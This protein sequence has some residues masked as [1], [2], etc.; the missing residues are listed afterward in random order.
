MVALFFD[1]MLADLLHQLRD[2]APAVALLVQHLVLTMVAM[3]LVADRDLGLFEVFQVGPI[4]AGRIV[5]GK[6]LAHLLVG[7]AVSAALLVGVAR[8]LEPNSVALKELIRKAKV[9]GATA[10]AS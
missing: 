10:A 9:E 5:V 2:A 3:S 4:G 1:H 8:L 7:A 6:Y